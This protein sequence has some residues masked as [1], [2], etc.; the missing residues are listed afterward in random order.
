MALVVLIA[1]FLFGFVFAGLNGGS[2]PQGSTTISPPKVERHHGVKCSKRMGA[3][4][5][6]KKC[7]GPPANP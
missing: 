6:L 3:G 1:A 4:E 7:G 5:N 2:G